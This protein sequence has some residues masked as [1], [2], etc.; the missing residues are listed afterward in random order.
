M[1]LKLDEC[2]QSLSLSAP[3]VGISFAKRKF[4]KL[5]PII[6]PWHLILNVH[7]NVQVESAALLSG[8]EEKQAGAEEES[9]TMKT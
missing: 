4:G 7:C 2:Y 8:V 5:S 3:N 9:M 6:G 1:C